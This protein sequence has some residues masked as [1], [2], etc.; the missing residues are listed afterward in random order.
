MSHSISSVFPSCFTSPFTEVRMR[1]PW[2]SQ[3]VTRPGPSGQSVSEPFTRS[4][5]PASVSRKSWS[6]KSFPIVYPAMYSPASSGPTWRHSRPM[7]MA[8][9]PS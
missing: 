7:T 5:E 4:I 1:L 2:K 6:P 9:S 8:I 3:S